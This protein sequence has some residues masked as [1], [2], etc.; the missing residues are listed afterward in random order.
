[1]LDA[2]ALGCMRLA[3]GLVRGGDGG[4]ERD[5]VLPPGR[6]WGEHRAGGLGAQALVAGV[7]QQGDARG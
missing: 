3:F 6:P 4:E 5:L 1:M 2:D 7:G